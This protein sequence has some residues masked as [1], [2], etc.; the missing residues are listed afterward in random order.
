MAKRKPQ[1]LYMR[2]E[3]YCIHFS[4]YRSLGELEVG[5]LRD[6]RVTSVTRPTR[7][8]RDSDS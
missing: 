8:N 6:V 1:M 7:R 2:L 4:L 3:Y 5:R